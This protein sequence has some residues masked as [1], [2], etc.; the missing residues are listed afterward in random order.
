MTRHGPGQKTSH[1]F[2]MLLCWLIAMIAFS[3]L[4]LPAFGRGRHPSLRGARQAFR[5]DAGQIASRLML[6]QATDHR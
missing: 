6:S 1:A 2:L 3:M 5:N 4:A